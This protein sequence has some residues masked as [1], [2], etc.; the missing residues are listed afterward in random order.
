METDA[1]NQENALRHAQADANSAGDE[2]TRL[3]D[4]LEEARAENERLRT[5]LAQAQAEPERLREEIVS[6]EKDLAFVKYAALGD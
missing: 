5:E 3:R 6:L 2:I 4:Q 1:I